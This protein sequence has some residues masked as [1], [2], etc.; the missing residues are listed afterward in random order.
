MNNITKRIKLWLI[1]SPFIFVV[2][3]LVSI[4]INNLANDNIHNPLVIGGIGI[5]ITLILCLITDLK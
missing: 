1:L 5:V 3:Y 2:G 4:F